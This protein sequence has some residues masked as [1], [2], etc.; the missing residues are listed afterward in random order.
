MASWN[1]QNEPVLLTFMLALILANILIVVT[2]YLAE[3][4]LKVKCL[5]GS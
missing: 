4:V 3:T 2:K 1:L 5:L